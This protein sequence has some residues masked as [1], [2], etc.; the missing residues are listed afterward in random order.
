MFFSPSDLFTKNVSGNLGAQGH[1][2]E[3]SAV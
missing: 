3:L 2:E 1:G